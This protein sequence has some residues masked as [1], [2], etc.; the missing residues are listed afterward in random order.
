MDILI[1]TDVWAL[2]EK[3]SEIG[4][5]LNVVHTIDRECSF[6]CRKKKAVAART[7]LLEPE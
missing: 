1:D 2:A 4:K 7:D 5:P 6:W 3:L